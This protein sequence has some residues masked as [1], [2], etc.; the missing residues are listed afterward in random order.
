MTSSKEYLYWRQFN[1]WENP[2]KNTYHGIQR[3]MERSKMHPDD[4]LLIVDAGATVLLG[5]FEE[6]DYLLFFSPQ[7][8]GCKIAVTAKEKT[9]LVSVWDADFHLP[10]GVRKPTKQD[11]REARR[12]L[13]NMLLGRTC[14]P[15]SMVMDVLVRGIKGTQIVREERLC[16]INRDEALNPSVCMQLAHET[17]VRI[18]LSLG[19]EVARKKNRP[20]LAYRLIV[21]DPASGDHVRHFEITHRTVL[22]KCDQ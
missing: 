12:L 3:V 20:R 1:F 7:D 5:T 16:G 22:N 8:R 2:V 9:R 10:E 17:L 11:I 15:L 18:A 21:V 14:Q 19:E 4:V 13:S 6:Y